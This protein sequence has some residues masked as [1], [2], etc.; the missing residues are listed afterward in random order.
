MRIGVISDT[1]GLLRQQ[2][3]AALQGCAHILHAGDVGDDK[4]LAALRN[5]APLTAIR[6]N[7][8]RTGAC[9]ALPPVEAVELAGKLIYMVHARADLDLNPRAA[10]I[11]AFNSARVMFMYALNEVAPMS[12]QYSTVARAC[13]GLVRCGIWMK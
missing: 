12:A 9:A 6:G 4:I 5:I 1:H 7:I 8:D 10:S 3:I 13:S 11:A 2:A